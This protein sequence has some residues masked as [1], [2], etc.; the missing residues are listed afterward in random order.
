MDPKRLPVGI[1]WSHREIFGVKKSQ[2]R[3]FLILAK[4]TTIIIFKGRWLRKAS[5]SW[6]NVWPPKR[7][8]TTIET[9]WKSS[10]IHLRF[11]YSDI[12]FMDTFEMFGGLFHVVVP[13]VSQCP[14]RLFDWLFLIEIMYWAPWISQ[15]QRFELLS[16]SLREQPWD[17]IYLIG[18][19]YNVTDIQSLHSMV[20]S[21][22]ARSFHLIVRLLHR[23]IVRTFHKSWSHQQ[24]QP[25]GQKSA[26]HIQLYT[27]TVG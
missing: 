27:E 17:S 3:L 9:I 4:G 25:R 26:F 11:H 12:V 13:D 2:I 14:L 20:R 18:L 16:V 10:K 24:K 7:C 19:P 5:C 23:A 21:F 6:G 8:Q 15:V 22:Q 1:I